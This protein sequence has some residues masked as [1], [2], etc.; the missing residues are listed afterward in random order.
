MEQENLRASTVN[1]EKEM[2]IAKYNA[3]HAKTD[4]KNTKFNNRLIFLIS[5]LCSLIL[6][7]FLVNILRDYIFENY[8]DQGFYHSIVYWISYALISANICFFIRY[9]IVVSKTLITY[10]SPES[11]IVPRV[12][13]NFSFHISIIIAMWMSCFYIPLGLFIAENSPSFVIGLFSNQTNLKK[14]SVD[15]RLEGFIEKAGIE[16]SLFLNKIVPVFLLVIIVVTLRDM[17]IYLLNFKIHY[18]YYS[19]RIN[20]NTQQIA[21]IKHINAFVE[22]NYD[23]DVDKIA[24][25]FIQK[26]TSNGTHPAIYQTLLHY[27]EAELAAEIYLKCSKGDGEELTAE[28]IKEFYIT[29]LVEHDAIAKSIEQHNSTVMSFK[30]VLNVLAIPFCFYKILQILPFYKNSESIIFG[31]VHATFSIFF[32]MNYIFSDSLKNF[33]NSLNFIFFIRPYEIGDLL[34]IDDKLLKVHSIK[35]L[36]TIFYDG[37]NYILIPNTQLSNEK[38]KNLRLNGTWTVEYKNKFNTEKFITNSVS[39]LDKLDKFTKRNSSEYKERP[40]FRKV[41]LDSSST[42]NVTLFVKFNADVSSV[43]VLLERKARF[44]F[45]YQDILSQ[46]GMLE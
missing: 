30:D 8:S 18:D 21:L 20:K 25:A 31:N 40:C 5:S 43:D 33:M 38:I 13:E 32:T 11:L 35:L 17:A 45:S 24:E 42:A 23:T 2:A 15:E 37:F 22:A 1:L 16:D 6:T 39:I 19:Q 3:Y 12:F 34:V 28:K 29:T 36:T 46:L 27:F 14:E 10:Y 44:F 9:L 4:E 41:E 26:V 7:L